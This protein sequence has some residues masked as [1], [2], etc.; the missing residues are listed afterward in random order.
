MAALRPVLPEGPLVVMGDF[1]NN[2]I[3]DNPG[4]PRWNHA[5][6]VQTL[7]DEFGL[8]SACH[9]YFKVE[10]GQGNHPTLCYKSRQDEPS[11]IDYVFVPR[12]WA[13]RITRVEVSNYEG[14]QTSYHR[15]LLV[16]LALP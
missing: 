11:H 7:S 3:W 16:E 4:T 6:I 9:H 14:W 13:D 5:R 12:D 1:N 15:P 8:V 10:H 2:T